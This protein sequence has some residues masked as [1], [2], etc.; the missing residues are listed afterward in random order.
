MRR[1]KGTS[2]ERL[3]NLGLRAR[4]QICCSSDSGSDWKKFQA[5]RLHW[6]WKGPVTVLNMLFCRSNLGG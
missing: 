1:G 2:D 5:S 6:S 3:A 4:L